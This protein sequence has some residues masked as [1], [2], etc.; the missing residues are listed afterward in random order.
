MASIQM[1]VR[2]DEGLKETGDKVFAKLGYSPTHVVRAIWGYAAH[3]KDDPSQVE[4]MLQ[5]AERALSPD[6]NEERAR[7]MQLAEAGPQT[8]T[9]FLANL[10]I[11][12]ELRFDDEDLSPAE[13]RE[14][15][16]LE[17]ARE[18]GW[19]DE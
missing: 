16:A 3:C 6:A 10:G 5:E 4:A 17:R 1:N 12:G 2:I 15:A 9:H 8:F 7:R 11:E 14:Q 13:I 18:K 19:I